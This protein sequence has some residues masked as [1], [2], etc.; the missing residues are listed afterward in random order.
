VSPSRILVVDDDRS[1]RE[2]LR[3]ILQDEGYP[4]MVAANGREAL[5]RLEASPGPPSLCIVDLVMPI[6]D[7]WQLCAEFARRPDLVGVPVVVVSANAT[8]KGPPT[9]LHTL[10]V[11][12]KPI[13]FERLLA[14]VEHYCGAG[15]TTSAT[16]GS[17]AG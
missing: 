4:V 5:D 7:G 12:K 3:T 11:M 6:L 8:L 16:T 14:Y 13:S 15:A 17:S 1:I 2:T 9:G 10:H